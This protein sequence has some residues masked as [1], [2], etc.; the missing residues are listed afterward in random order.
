MIREGAEKSPRSQGQ[1]ASCS[2][3]AL[4]AGTGVASREERSGLEDMGPWLSVLPTGAVP[5][6]ASPNLWE[7]QRLSVDI[8]A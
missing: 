2:G 4:W 3:F 1:R 6:L 7:P 8:F 5:V